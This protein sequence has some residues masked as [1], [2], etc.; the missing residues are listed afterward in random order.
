MRPNVAGRPRKLDD[1]QVKRVKWLAAQDVPETYIAKR[2]A[3]SPAT[4]RKA[5]GKRRY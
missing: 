3:V 5:L 2:M 4:I 1:K